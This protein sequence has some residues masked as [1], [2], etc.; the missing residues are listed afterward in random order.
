MCKSQGHIHTHTHTHTHADE[1]AGG[2]G[3]PT[4]PPTNQPSEKI[5][6]QAGEREEEEDEKGRSACV[7]NDVNRRVTSVAF[8][9]SV[10]FLSLSLSLLHRFYSTSA[11]CAFID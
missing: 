1:W 10:D 2:C 8:S 6:K 7:S 11:G 4:P 5:T 3:S 9:C